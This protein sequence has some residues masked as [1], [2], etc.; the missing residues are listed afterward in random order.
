MEY[1]PLI[2]D[3][4]GVTC[5][6]GVAGLSILSHRESVRRDENIREIENSYHMRIKEIYESGTRFLDE[7]NKQLLL[8]N[9]KIR[10]RPFE[11]EKITRG[12]QLI[13]F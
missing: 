12:F 13:Q 5:F 6:I 11:I 10:A 1:V 4:F 7:A 9:Q 8:L 2:L 3:G